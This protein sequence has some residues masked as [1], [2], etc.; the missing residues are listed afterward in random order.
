MMPPWLT[1]NAI[2]LRDSD[3]NE[4]NYRVTIYSILLAEQLNIAKDD[5]QNLIIGA[6]LHDV[7]K[8]GISDTILLKNGKLTSDEFDIMKL[9][10]QKGMTIVKDNIWLEKGKDVICSHHEKY[11]GSGYPKKISKYDIP[12]IARIFSIVDVFDALT[13]KRPY[14]EP[15]SYQKAIDILKESSGSHFDPTILDIFIKISDKLYHNIS[16]EF[17]QQLKDELDSL[18]TKYFLGD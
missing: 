13:S 6:F 16:T 5:M 11:D 3:T 15:F 8:I 1:G 18:I 10:V 7:G 17:Q 2:A 4:H 14:K 9:H 12:Q